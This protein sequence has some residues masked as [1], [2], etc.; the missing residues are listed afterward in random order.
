[1]FISLSSNVYDP[2][3]SAVIKPVPWNLN[4]SLICA[5][6]VCIYIGSDVRII[7]LFFT[8]YLFTFS[9]VIYAVLLI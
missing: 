5:T 8:C 6:S 3:L 7:E 2:E 9:D 1:M 4:K